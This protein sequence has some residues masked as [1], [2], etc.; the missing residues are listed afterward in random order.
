MPISPWSV[1][2]LAVKKK[3]AECFFT[4]EL[5]QSVQDW[6]LYS[7]EES[8]AFM[9]SMQS[10]STTSSSA[11]SPHFSSAMI[12]L[13]Q[14]ACCKKGAFFPAD[15]TAHSVPALLGCLLLL[16][17]CASHSPLLSP[18]VKFTTRQGQVALG[19]LWWLNVYQKQAEKSMAS[20]KRSRRDWIL[21]L[22]ITGKIKW[23]KGGGS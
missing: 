1:F 18:A 5:Q 8:G 10:T 17:G 2:C 16:A 19:N 9:R 12:N 13:L 15:P 6:F 11:A 7:L 21:S 14:Q 22:F 4:A 23:L 3:G 20:I